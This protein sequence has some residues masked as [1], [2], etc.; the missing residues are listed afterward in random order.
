MSGPYNMG[1]GGEPG[2]DRQ[3]YNPQA[4]ARL[5]SAGFE[6]STD[7][8]L[9]SVAPRG[10]DNQPTA[11]NAAR[12]DKEAEESELSGRIPKGEVDALVGE[13]GPDERNVRGKTRG[14]RVDAYKQ[15]KD[16]DKA[17]ADIDRAEQDVEIGAAD[18]RHGL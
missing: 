9:V 15:E 18:G 6:A 8:E 17:L 12:E 5:D 11:V 7:P 13:L 16:L 14:V 4:D 2:V 1:S 10:A 3:T